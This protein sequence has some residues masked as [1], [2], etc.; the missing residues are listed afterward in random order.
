MYRR[1]FIKIVPAAA[2]FTAVSADSF[3]LTE[4]KPD[5]V[6]RKYWVEVAEKIMSPVIKELSKG[7]LRNAMPVDVKQGQ[8]SRRKYPYLEAFGRTLAGIAPW[9]ELEDDN[10]PE[11]LKRKIYFEW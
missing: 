11:G 10:T 2:A 8:E 3:A 9:L 4:I 5:P 1:N 6:S 7:N